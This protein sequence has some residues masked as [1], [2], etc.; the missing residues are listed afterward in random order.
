MAEGEGW[1]LLLAGG[2]ALLLSFYLG[3]VR[4]VTGA[5]S[6][7]FHRREP[8]RG[9]RAGKP[10]ADAV[11]GSGGCARARGTA[12]P[13]AARCAP[14]LGSGGGSCAPKDAGCL[15]GLLLCVGA[16]CN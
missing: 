6:T 14:F 3:F 1:E 5:A 11:S 9:E 16:R 2:A 10:P 4:R 7:A 12:A 8:G 13:Q 15:Q